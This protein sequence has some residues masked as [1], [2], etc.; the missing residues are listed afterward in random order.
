M[1]LLLNLEKNALLLGSIW[2]GCG[3]VYLLYL[4]KFFRVRLPEMSISEKMPDQVAP[5]ARGSVPA[6]S[7]I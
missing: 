2:L 6:S 3:I 5:D 1:G 4:S 7:T